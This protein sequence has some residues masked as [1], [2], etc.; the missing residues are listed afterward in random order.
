MGVDGV[1][2]TARLGRANED[3]KNVETSVL[4]LKRV[5]T[6]QATDMSGKTGVIFH[7]VMNA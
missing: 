3:Q 4:V 1:V 6:H 5:L 2:Q 7:I